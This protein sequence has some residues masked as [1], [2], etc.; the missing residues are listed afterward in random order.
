MVNPWHKYHKDNQFKSPNHPCM[1][2]RYGSKVHIISQKQ[3]GRTETF[4]ERYSDKW[5]NLGRRQF[6]C[7]SW[8][9]WYLYF[10]YSMLQELYARF[11][12]W[13]IL[14][15]ADLIHILQGYFTA[16]WLIIWSLQCLLSNPDRHGVGITKALFIN[17]SIFE[18]LDL[19]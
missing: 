5:V 18:N 16:V 4:L 8:A 17:F 11:L 15:L 3:S 10:M 2:A 12:F 1:N 9:Q 13:C 7:N 19:S 14:I 6:C